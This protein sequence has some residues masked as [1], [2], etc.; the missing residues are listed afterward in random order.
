MSVLYC[1]VTLPHCIP[2]TCDI[3]N[4]KKLDVQHIHSIKIFYRLPFY[5]QSVNKKCDVLS[6]YF[7]VY[8]IF[9]AQVL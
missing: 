7:L 2:N 9:Q 1:V 3:V 6:F 4:L 5:D 8:L